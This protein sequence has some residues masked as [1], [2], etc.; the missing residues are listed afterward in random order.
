MGLT[1][2]PVFVRADKEAPKKKWRARG[3]P[4][5]VSV[6]KRRWPPSPAAYSI[7]SLRCCGR[8]PSGPAA[9]VLGKERMA[10]S[11]SSA[12]IRMDVIPP[13]AGAE[14]MVESGWGDGCLSLRA[15][16]VSSLRFAMVSLEDARRTVTLK[17]SSSSLANIRAASISRVVVVV[18]G[19]LCACQ[20]GTGSG[21]PSSAISWLVR[22]ARLLW[23]PSLLEAW[24]QQMGK[25]TRRSQEVVE[26]SLT[27]SSRMVAVRWWEA[28]GIFLRILCVGRLGLRAD[29][30]II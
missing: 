8:R 28:R 20:F 11:T 25:R 10:L 14:G 13:M 17:S 15:V 16:R 7:M 27:T 9:E 3:E 1:P 24:R 6:L 29:T 23:C 19:S 5:T 30:E 4:C 21:S 22:E 18:Y 26:L 12:N 2:L